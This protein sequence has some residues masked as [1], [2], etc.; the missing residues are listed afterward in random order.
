M[1]YK[2]AW[3]DMYRWLKQGKEYLEKRETE[4]S[5]VEGPYFALEEKRTS[6]KLDGIKTCMNHM[7]ESEKLYHLG[8]TGE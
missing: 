1:D 7:E 4:L 2:E 8:E 5:M 3:D 6:G